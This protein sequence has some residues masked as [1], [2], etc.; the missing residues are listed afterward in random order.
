VIGFRGRAD[1]GFTL[2]ELLVASLIS[3]VVMGVLLRLAVTA[4]RQTRT[5]ADAADLQQRLRVAA[6]RIRADLVMAGAGPSTG[7]I[8]FASLV[9]AVVPARTGTRAA[10]PVVTF[11]NDRI[12][13][14]RASGPGAQ[15]SLVSAMAGPAAWLAIDTT[16]AGCAGSAGCGFAAGDRALVVDPADPALAFDVFTVADAGAGYVSPAGPL[17]R[18]YAA[19]SLVVKI[20]ERIYYLDRPGLRLML[21]DGD[22][23]DV[24]L[25]D[26]VVD[27][28]F[29][30]FVDPSAVSV[31][32]PAAG[33]STCVYSA[34]SP[35]ASLLSELGG[36]ALQPADASLLTDGPICGGGVRRYDADLLRVRRI[37]V[38]LRLE[39]EAA[40]LRASG[41][42]F[43]RPGSSPGGVDEVADEQ[44]TFDVAPRNMNLSR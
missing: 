31:P 18:P 16:A 34:G 14:L 30:Y 4:Q 26:H 13:I 43:A 6:D 27:L 38:T 42:R 15:T 21:Y 24:P 36:L 25:V 17:A 23:S 33:T 35:P 9:P 8:P 22:A 20:V 7:S 12:S 11:F 32:P 37:R 41:A 44:V 2:I 19:G 1:R 40:E 3:C 10:D 29:T 5:L 28:R 39:A